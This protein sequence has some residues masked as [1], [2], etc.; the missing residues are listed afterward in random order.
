M[1][2]S[3]TTERINYLLYWNFDQ[4][5]IGKSNA[6]WLEQNDFPFISWSYGIPKLVTPI[7]DSRAFGELLEALGGLEG[8]PIINEYDYDE[9]VEELEVEWVENY[10]RENSVTTKAVWESFDSSG[11]YLEVE[12]D[13][14]YLSY[15][16]DEEEFL[17]RCTEA[18]Q[19]WETHYFSG[20]THHPEVCAYCIEAKEVA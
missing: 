20:M 6:R 2:S 15:A 8:Y 16:S 13:G 18:S 9:L 7:K 1:A 3:G 11:N 14:V 4:G 17:R 19:S 5:V 12:G 10:A